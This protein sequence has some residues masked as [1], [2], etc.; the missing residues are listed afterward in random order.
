MGGNSFHHAISYGRFEMVQ[1]FIN[2]GKV[3][4]EIVDVVRFSISIS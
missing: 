1:M 2:T 4:F 3:D